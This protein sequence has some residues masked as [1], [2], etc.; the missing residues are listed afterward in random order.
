V[1]IFLGAF[2]QPGSRLVTVIDGQSA[3]AATRRRGSGERR[4]V[5]LRGRRAEHRQSSGVAPPSAHRAG[6][7]VWSQRQG[8][9]HVIPSPMLEQHG[10]KRSPH[11]THR[12]SLSPPPGAQVVPL[13]EHHWPPSAI[14][15]QGW[16]SPPQVPHE[17]V[18]AHVPWCAP[19]VLPLTT[20]RLAPSSSVAQQPLSQRWAWQQGVPGRPHLV[21]MA[22][23]F[24][25]QTFA[26][27]VQP[28]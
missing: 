14:R 7:A 17:P 23:P 27:S 22:S 5:F 13:A 18:P 2:A 3:S 12:L 9:A 8:S 21:Q 11:R 26:G 19:Q 10:W 24:G 15:Q 1:L 25:W 6:I 28:S 16:L 4:A 20:Q